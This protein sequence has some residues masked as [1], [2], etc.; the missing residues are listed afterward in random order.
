MLCLW[1][2]CTRVLYGPTGLGYSWAT[3]C[4][5][6]QGD[7]LMHSDCVCRCHLHVAG[8]IEAVTKKVHS[9]RS[10]S[11]R[12]AL[13][14][15]RAKDSAAAPRKRA[16]VSAA[17]PSTPADPLPVPADPLPADP[18]VQRTI[19]MLRAKCRE[20]CV[21]VSAD[22]VRRL[23]STFRTVR[24][25]VDLPGD[26]Y[27]STQVEVLPDRQLEDRHAAAPSFERPQ[28]LQK[29]DNWFANF[30]MFRRINMLRH[31]GVPVVTPDLP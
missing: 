5:K 15:K 19:D 28:G 11:N 1:S 22:V 3:F 13:N 18:P 29:R 17:A 7:H 20:G 12:A 21:R 10:G 30:D 23:Q 4:K 8:W 2:L 26:E 16:K 25:R 31:A 9:A 27:A 14:R 6:F 24:G